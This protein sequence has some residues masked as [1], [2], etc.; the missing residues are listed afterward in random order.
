MDIE[1][2]LGIDPLQLE[3]EWLRQ[4]LLYQKAAEDLEEH[5]RMR[6]AANLSLDETVASVRANITSAPEKHGL[7][8]KATV[9]SINDATDLNEEIKKSKR[10]YDSMNRDFQH[11]QNVLKSIDQKKKALENLVQLYIGQY[12]SIPKEGKQIDGGKRRFEEQAAD[13]AADKQRSRLGR[14]TEPITAIAERAER[15]DEEKINS[16]SKKGKEGYEEVM[17]SREA[18]EGRERKPVRRKKQ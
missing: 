1:K 6:D 4:P 3:E 5:M 2:E 7:K 13:K 17:K 10:H 16:M 8:E 15:T 18:K 11:A 12:F 14:F 9:G